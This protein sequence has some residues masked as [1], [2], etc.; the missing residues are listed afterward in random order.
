MPQRAQSFNLMMCNSA[1]F[2]VHCYAEVP[3]LYIVIVQQCMSASE[4]SAVKKLESA[5]IK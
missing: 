1:V 4:P 5:T 3:L 2:S